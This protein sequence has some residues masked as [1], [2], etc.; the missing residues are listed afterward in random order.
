MTSNIAFYFSF[1]IFLIVILTTGLPPLDTVSG[2]LYASLMVFLLCISGQLILKDVFKLS[3]KTNRIFYLFYLAVL[4]I[5]FVVAMKVADTYVLGFTSIA[6]VLIV[7]RI[8]LDSNE[9]KEET[10]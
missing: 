8:Y 1:V 7:L 6:F 10:Q 2:V 4:L 3:K 9:E 5:L